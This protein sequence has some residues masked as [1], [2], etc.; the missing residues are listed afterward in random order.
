MPVSERYTERPDRYRDDDEYEYDRPRRRR[1][2]EVVESGGS[3]GAVCGAVSF[4]LALLSGLGFL[5]M[6][7]AAV[8][9]A[10]GSPTGRAAPN[11][12]GT[13]L[14]GL[15]VIGCGV[16]ALVGGILGVVGVCLP[17]RS[18]ILTILGL[19]FNGLIVL[20]LVGL[21]GLGLAMG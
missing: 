2:P 11:S 6:I 20:S 9:M 8:A 17:G 13:M 7:V 15:L 19:I 10:A 18:K 12:P 5:V 3:I 1:R 4:G 21:C 16:L 14:L